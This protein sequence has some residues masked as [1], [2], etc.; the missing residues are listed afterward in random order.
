MVGMALLNTI[1][2]KKLPNKLLPILYI[3]NEFGEKE[4]SLSELL[5]SIEFAQKRINLGYYFSNRIFHSDQ[6][7]E[8]IEKL[9]D[10]GYIIMYSYKHD[11]YFPKRFISL[12]STGMKKAQ[13]SFKSLPD[14]EVVT[15]RGAV[16]KAIEENKERYKIWS[17]PLFTERKQF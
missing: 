17:R 15:I 13:E 12:T 16:Q 8:E 11:G 10:L 14:D 3:F 7:F 1:R 4:I 6:V 2:R 5:E 9:K